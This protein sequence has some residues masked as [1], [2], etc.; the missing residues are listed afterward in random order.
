MKYAAIA[1]LLASVPTAAWADCHMIDVDGQLHQVCDN[2]PPPSADFSFGAKVLLEALQA[3]TAIRQAQQSQEQ[4]ELQSEQLRVRR[5]QLAQ[6][7]RDGARLAH[8]GFV[9]EMEIKTLQTNLQSVQSTSSD[10]K[11][12]KSA[13]DA[14]QAIQQALDVLEPIDTKL[15]PLVL[16]VPLDIRK[17]AFQQMADEAS[18][19]IVEPFDPAKYQEWTNDV[20]QCVRDYDAG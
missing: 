5:K 6:Q 11:A 16:Q 7:R 4:L 9:M 1:V 19:D 8:C 13:Q 18:R 3:A 2:S 14:I 15:H 12:D 17:A 20:S 10:H